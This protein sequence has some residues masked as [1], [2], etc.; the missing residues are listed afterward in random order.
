MADTRRNKG[1]TPP[2][3]RQAGRAILLDGAG[4]SVDPFRHARG[5][6]VYTFWATPGGG[7]DRARVP[8]RRRNARC[9]RNW[10]WALRYMARFTP[11]SVFSNMTG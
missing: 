2:A 7:V 4:G 8:W 3:P 9:W 10:A 6:E 1:K 11:L 5:D